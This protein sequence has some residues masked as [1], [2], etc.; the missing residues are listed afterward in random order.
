MKRLTNRHIRL[1]VS[2]ALPFDNDGDADEG[3]GG[4]EGV[5]VP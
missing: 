3:G 2:A 4:E 5:G 1:D